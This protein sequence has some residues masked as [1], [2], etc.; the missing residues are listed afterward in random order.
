VNE[1]RSLANDR[2]RNFLK[3]KRLKSNTSRWA[4]QF[5]SCSHLSEGEQWMVDRVKGGSSQ[6]FYSQ[7][8]QEKITPF[9]H[10][11]LSHICCSRVVLPVTTASEGLC[12]FNLIISIEA[13]LNMWNW[14]WFHIHLCSGRHIFHLLSYCTQ[15][16]LHSWR[17]TLRTQ[18]F[19]AHSS[20]ASAIRSH[21]STVVQ[22]K[23][24]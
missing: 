8:C 20:F 3:N 11:P 23:L 7:R 2:N 14:E 19:I 22:G 5:T 6:D 12:R 24:L 4:F 18:N 21:A 9:N 16:Q 10:P 17:H 13:Y 15:L 1:D